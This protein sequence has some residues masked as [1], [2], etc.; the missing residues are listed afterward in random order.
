MVYLRIQVPTRIRIQ[1][2]LV[3]LYCAE[4]VH[5]AQALIWTRTPI[6]TVLIY[7][8][9]IPAKIGIRVL[10]RQCKQAIRC[11]WTRTIGQK[12]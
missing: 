2:A 11:I 6:T 3:T 7:E 1:N 8:M 4:H 10:V 12:I 5:I 9:D